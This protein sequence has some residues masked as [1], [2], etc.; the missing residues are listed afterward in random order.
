MFGGTCGAIYKV[1]VGEGEREKRDRER[2]RAQLFPLST[3]KRYI[4]PVQGNI[5]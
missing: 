2:E 4:S 5:L 1:G 3:S